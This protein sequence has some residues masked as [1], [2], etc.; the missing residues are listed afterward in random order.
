M[1]VL[2]ESDRLKSRPTR[3]TL[4]N[5]C[6]VRPLAQKTTRKF[7]QDHWDNLWLCTEIAGDSGNLKEMC[8]AIKTVTRPSKQTC[9]VLKRKDGTAIDDNQQ[10]L[11]K[12]VEHYRGTEGDTCQD[13]LA[14]LPN[15][16]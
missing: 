9:E 1:I 11:E 13:T 12:F 2:K 15:L 3:Q 5:H 7:I 14:N 6:A 4:E 10:K 8:Y 16:A